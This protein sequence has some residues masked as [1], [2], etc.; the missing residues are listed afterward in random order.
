MTILVTG[1]AGYVGSHMVRHLCARGAAVAVID[2]LRAGHRDAVPS[3]VPF[4]EANVADRAPVTA[5]LRKHHIDSVLHFAALSQVG[6][7][8]LHPQRYFAG[9]VVSTLSLLDSVLEAGIGTFVL[10]ST[11]AVYGEPTAPLLT[12]THPTVPVNPYGLSKLMIEQALAEYARAYSLRFA[13]L[14]YFNAAGAADD[15]SLGERHEP[16]SHLIPLVMDA[17]MG[18][19]AQVTIFGDDYPTPDGTCI[20]DYIHVEDLAEAH[21]QVLRSLVNGGASGA[22]NLGSGVGHSVREVIAAVERVS[23]LPVPTVRGP[24][25]AGDPARLVASPIKAGEAFG[26]QVSR[27]SLQRIVS[28][29]WRFHQRAFVRIPR[30]VSA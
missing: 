16:E 25:R 8:V 3:T 1:G 14:R 15:G 9:N 21:H 2:D 28:D 13:C 26:F 5:F 18:R 24:R 12:E 10:S 30:Q 20:R 29:A 6:E 11:A 27:S 7:S 4:L 19:R 22:F 23:G 17:A